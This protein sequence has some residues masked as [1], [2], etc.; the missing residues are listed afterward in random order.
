MRIEPRS[1]ATFIVYNSTQ[2]MLVNGHGYRKFID[3]F[4]KPFF[5]SKTEESQRDI[6]QLN[7]DVVAKLCKTVKRS[8]VKY[9]NGSAFP[10]NGCVFAAKSFATLKKHKRSDHSLSFETSEKI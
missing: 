3:L 6:E 1:F 10:C 4:L 2:R 9:K 5:V 8:D 7:G